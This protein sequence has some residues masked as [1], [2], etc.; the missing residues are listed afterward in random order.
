LTAVFAVGCGGQGGERFRVASE[1]MLPTYTPGEEVDVDTDASKLGRGEVVV[2]H[3]PTGAEE[4]VCGVSRPPSA[5]CPRATPTQSPNKF[6]QRIVAVGGDRVKVVEG[7]VALSGKTLEERYAR[8]DGSW[9]P[10]NLPREITVPTGQL[11]VMGD[12]RGVS[13]DSREWGPIP[14]D[15]I[16]GKVD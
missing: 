15:W 8:P 2:F 1:S 7:L 14:K 5:A 6:I 9:A 4:N 12:N 13:A 3:P 10:C 11:F 16:V